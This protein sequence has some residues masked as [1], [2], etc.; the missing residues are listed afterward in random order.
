MGF[1]VARILDPKRV[2]LRRIIREEKKFNVIR[3]C[4]SKVNSSS[5]VT[6]QQKKFRVNKDLPNK[7]AII[8]MVHR[9]IDPSTV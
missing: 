8:K 3:V 1:V 2:K 6:N 7:A 5:I 4:F 9:K